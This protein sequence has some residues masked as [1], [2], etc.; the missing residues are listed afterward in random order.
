MSFANPFR[1]M[2][3]PVNDLRYA[4]RMLWKTPGF[5]L[6]A[7]GLLAAGIGASTL[8]F[9]ALDAVFLRPLPV[10]HPEELVRLVQ[11]TPQLGTRSSF[12]YLYYQSLRDH[13]SSLSAVFAEE[14]WDSAMTEPAPAEEVKATLV[15][16]EFFDIFGV[17]ALHGRTLTRADET[18]DQGTPP[19]VLSYAL[20]SRRFNGDPAAVGRII[21]LHGHKFI[22][23]GVMP[24]EFNGIS[25]DTA[26][27]LMVPVRVAPLLID[28][29]G[30]Q[31]LRV[32]MLPNFE[33]V[34]R[35]RPGV[36]LAQ[37]QAECPRHL[38]DIDRGVLQGISGSGGT[39]AGARH[40]IGA[41]RARRVHPTG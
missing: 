9:S 8:M 34:A 36:T 40:G 14:E 39:G 31:P 35:L 15:T 19:A 2:M 3:D 32:E 16:P 13:A 33:L 30:T 27:D 17:A 4:A 38:P 29:G 24:R 28:V 20:W 18:V 7:A 6:V 11:K 21:T 10:K 23:V 5:T 41:A 12:S 26:P 25:V 37:A 1:D 22:V